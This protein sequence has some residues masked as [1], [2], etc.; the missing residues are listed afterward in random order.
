MPAGGPTPSAEEIRLATLR[1]SADC[2]GRRG[3]L[4][5]RAAPSAP[6]CGNDVAGLSARRRPR[7]DSK[8]ASTS[9]G[10]QVERGDVLRSNRAEV[11][12]IQRCKLSLAESLDDGDN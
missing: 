3:P 4:S 8:P 11:A 7:R 2:S 12:V 9:C 10:E 6:A 1:A 5:G